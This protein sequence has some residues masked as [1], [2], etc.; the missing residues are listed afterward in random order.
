MKSLS[1][2]LLSISMVFFFG[3]CSSD[4]SG[5]EYQ[6][7]ET[8]QLQ[9]NAGDTLEFSIKFI[10]GEGIQQIVLSSTELDLDY[11]ENLSDQPL[12]LTRIFNVTIPN[13]A[14]S[15]SDYEIKLEFSSN[16]GFAK[17]DI[18]TIEIL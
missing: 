3:S 14:E 13:D 9:A 5:L 16:T 11:L 2:L 10:D 8:E 6:L 18:L 15:G 7:L 1:Y 17:E 4:D 12:E